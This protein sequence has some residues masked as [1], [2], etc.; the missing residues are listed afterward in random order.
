MTLYYQA[1]LTEFGGSPTP[2][3]TI[4]LNLPNHQSWDPDVTESDLIDARMKRINCRKVG[5]IDDERLEHFLTVKY[6]RVGHQLLDSGDQTSVFEGWRHC[7]NGLCEVRRREWLDDENIYYLAERL[8]TWSQEQEPARLGDRASGNWWI[9]PPRY[10]IRVREPGDEEGEMSAALG[11]VENKRVSDEFH[12]K[13]DKAKFTVHMVHLK[14][15]WA[16]LIYQH[17]NGNTFYLDS[18]PKGLQDRNRRARDEFRRW[19][20]ESDKVLPRGARHHMIRVPDQEDAWS[21]GLHALA[22]AMAFLR[23]ESLGWNKIQGWTSM[24]SRPMR[25][26][27]ITCLHQL[28]GLKFIPP[29]TPPTSNEKEH[30]RGVQKRA[31]TPKTSPKKPANKPAPRAKTP[32]PHSLGASRSPRGRQL[33]NEIRAAAE[34]EAQES[35]K[36]LAALRKQQESEQRAGRRA[37]RAERAASTDDV[38]EN[39]PAAGRRGAISAPTQSSSGT[40][41]KTA[42]PP[43]RKR[44]SSPAAA[45]H[46]EDGTSGPSRKRRKISGAEADVTEST[47]T[48]VTTPKAKAKAKASTAATST[49][50]TT[51]TESSPSK[52]RSTAAVSATETAKP[53]PDCKAGVRTNGNGNGYYKAQVPLNYKAQ[54]PIN[55]KAQVPVNKVP[56]RRAPVSQEAQGSGAGAH[57][58]AT[59]TGQEAQE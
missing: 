29:E 26:Q 20:R 39:P 16:V 33:S 13:F 14:N 4:Q 41:P 21:C 34:K 22:N 2:A 54:V 56:V 32:S 38:P 27:L 46:D 42:K 5:P 37:S 57:D 53:S 15:H 49:T 45:H 48:T 19:L 7:H 25:R 9:V 35:A 11:C 52:R 10:H 44:G 1:M 31:A 23:Y 59:A 17:S 24:G 28:M 43:S 12:E 3:P 36:R 18:L 40:S 58:A 8:I 50:T 55:Y 6:G 47:T 30:Q 51:T